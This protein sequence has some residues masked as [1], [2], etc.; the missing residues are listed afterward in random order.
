MLSCGLRQLGHEVVIISRPRQFD[1]IEGLSERAYNG[2]KFAKCESALATVGRE[3]RRIA[4]WNGE[5]F[6]GNR[7]RIVYRNRFDRGLL[8]DARNAGVDILSGQVLRIS[9][10]AECH[11]IRWRNDRGD[12]CHTRADIVIDARGRATGRRGQWRIGPRSIS[13]GQYWMLGRKQLPSTSIAT[14]EDGWA[15]FASCENSRVLIQLFLSLERDRLPPRRELSNMCNRIIHSLSEY[16]DQLRDAHP[17]GETT[18][19]DASTALCENTFT[20]GW[21]CVGDAAMSIDPLAGHGL[22]ES[23]SGALALVPVINTIV[24]RPGDGDVARRF[25]KE[26]LETDFWRMARV[27]RDFYRQ[28]TRWPSSAF[29]IERQQWPDERPAHSSPTDHAPKVADRPVSENGFICERKVIVTSDHPRGV[30]QV[31][32]AP[33][34]DLMEFIHDV[35]VSDECIQKA[36]GK[37]SVSENS[38]QTALSWLRARGLQ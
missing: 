2:L 33:L 32:G 37:F 23:V 5:R 28:E 7:E 10:T 19:R 31:A 26:K 4:N 12:I 24:R 6:E 13:I 25:Y 30:W 20:T 35:G 16:H 17:I 11:E 1:T 38:I 15:W 14:F 3:V 36:V 9:N 18:A 21:Y 29:W 27:G 22:Y 34:V 8:I